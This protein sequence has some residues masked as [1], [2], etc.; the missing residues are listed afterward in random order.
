MNLTIMDMSDQELASEVRK[1]K[2]II[3]T[4]FE[5]DGKYRSYFLEGQCGD[6]ALMLYN[7]FKGKSSI[8]ECSYHAVV[9]IGD[10][11]YDAGYGDATY[12]VLNSPNKFI[13]DDLTTEEGKAYFDL[14]MELCRKDWTK[15]QIENQENYMKELENYAKKELGYEYDHTLN[16]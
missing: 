12:S 16:K 6:F 14:F 11:Y 5:S 8:Y 9:K 7:I 13:E 10:N 1:A 15:E 2:D 3:I 4:K